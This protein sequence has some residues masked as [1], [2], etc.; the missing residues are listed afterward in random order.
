MLAFSIACSETS[1]TVSYIADMPDGTLTP[2]FAKGMLILFVGS[3]NGC[4]MKSH[5]LVNTRSPC[6]INHFNRNTVKVVHLPIS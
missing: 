3:V 2:G 5:A 6:S 1:D 4:I